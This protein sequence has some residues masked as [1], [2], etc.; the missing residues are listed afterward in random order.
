MSEINCRFYFESE[1]HLQ[2]LTDLHDCPAISLKVFG[3][4]LI[5]NIQVVKKILD[6]DTVII[7]KEYLDCR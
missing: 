6:I 1:H 2:S 5:L 3:Q 7:P 4:P